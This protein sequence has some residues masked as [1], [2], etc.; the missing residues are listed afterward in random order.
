MRAVGVIIRGVMDVV[1][2]VYPRVFT[3]WAAIGLPVLG[4][5]SGPIWQPCS[6]GCHVTGW[7]RRKGYGPRKRH[8][9]KPDFTHWRPRVFFRGGG[10]RIILHLVPIYS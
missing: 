5:K 1:L 6:L 9:S 10:K 4:G 7:P 2:V 3:G 8:P